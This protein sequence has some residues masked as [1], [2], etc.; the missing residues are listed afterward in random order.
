M[1]VAASPSTTILHEVTQ[2]CTSAT[3]DLVAMLLAQ[4]LTKRVILL[5]ATM[6]SP[7]PESILVFAVSTAFIL[8]L[9]HIKFHFRILSISN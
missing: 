4:A 6:A 5:A 7:N 9:I 1:S 8:F 3:M 2:S